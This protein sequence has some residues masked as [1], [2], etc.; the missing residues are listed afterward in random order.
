MKKERIVV[1]VVVVD[2]LLKL[3]GFNL[4]HQIFFL[5]MASIHAINDLNGDIIKWREPELQNKTCI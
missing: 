3:L 4:S 5:H 1:V 2:F